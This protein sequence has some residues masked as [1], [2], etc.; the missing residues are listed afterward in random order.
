MAGGE[1]TA[2]T[3]AA[4]AGIADAD[5]AAGR[6]RF[7]RRSFLVDRR[8]QLRVAALS[9]TV[10]LVLLV[11]LNLSIYSAGAEQAERIVR[12]SPELASWMRAQDR[13]LVSLVVLGSV[14]FLVGVFLV[15]ILETHKTAGACVNLVRRLEQ[16]RDGHYETALRLRRE[17][18]LRDIEPAFNGMCAALQ[19]RAW[20]DIETLEA[21]AARIDRERAAAD[22][23]AIASEIRSIAAGKRSLVE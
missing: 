4:R 14:V 20:D 19:Q 3:S 16:I 5:R 11:F 17:D 1:T 12:E 18:H 2:T 7:R 8:Y 22:V 10:V 9:S 23:A 6:P 15:S 21:L 13:T